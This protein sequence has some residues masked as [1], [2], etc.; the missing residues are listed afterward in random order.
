MKV[1]LGKPP[2]HRWYHKFFFSAL[3][4]ITPKAKQTITIDP[5]DTWCLDHTL[6][7]I[8]VPLLKQL[9]SAYTWCAK[10]SFLAIGPTFNWN[11]SRKKRGSKMSSILRHG[12]G[13]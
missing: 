10:G 13:L 2:A 6:S 3:L 9:K 12:I 4:V 11:S 1:I 7:Q 8:V 5:W